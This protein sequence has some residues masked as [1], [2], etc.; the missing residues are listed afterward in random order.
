M[1]ADIEYVMVA[2]PNDAHIHVRH[3]IKDTGRLWWQ[4][5]NSDAISGLEQYRN[6]SAFD[7]EIISD[8]PS[9]FDLD[10]IASR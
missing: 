5:P 6:I 4:Y 7:E 3:I 8:S 10:E 9:G 2:P 1:F